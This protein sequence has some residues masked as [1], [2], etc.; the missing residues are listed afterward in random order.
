[1]ARLTREESQMR[2]RELLIEAARQVVARQG[3][4]GASVGDIA[5]AAGF[6][7]GAFYSNFASK[8][9]ILLELLR[10]H[11]MRDIAEMRALLEAS[12]D[13]SAVQQAFRQ[14]F[15]SLDRDLEWALLA[16]ELQLQ[17]A[18]SPSFAAEYQALDGAYRSALA[19]L[20]GALFAKAGKA[21]PARLDDLAVAAITLAHGLAL[22]RAS[23]GPAQ[24]SERAGEIVVTFIEGLLAAAEPVPPAA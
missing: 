12:T 23:N 21:P 20:F 24:V 11:K 17:A 22:Q 10:R 1:M 15:A 14:R 2:T 8:E 9:G 16:N 18:R 3:Y 7:K 19:E 4:G 6:S 13:I 5:E